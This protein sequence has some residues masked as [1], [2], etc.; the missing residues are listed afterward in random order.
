MAEEL[1]AVGAWTLL[2]EA[3]LAEA[4]L[5]AEGIE[6]RLQGA[7]FAGVLPHMTDAIGGVRLLVP[8]SRAERAREILA[9]AGGA[10]AP[11]EDA[12]PLEAEPAG[13][14]RDAA[15]RRAWLAA[16]LGIFFL[17]VLLQL[18]SLWL[19][20]GYARAPGPASAR[21]RRQAAGALAVDL[22]VLGVAAAVA[23]AAL[24]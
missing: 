19:L 7:G 8:A 4:L 17:P 20:R 5:R 12:A 16:V 10:P 2:S 14:P 21:A 9:A 18:L 15:A 11:G 3:H 24:G 13:S 23:V 22:L 1:V 6:G